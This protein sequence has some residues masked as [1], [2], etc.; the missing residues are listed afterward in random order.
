MNTL[1]RSRLAGTRGGDLG[2]WRRRDRR[3]GRAVIGDPPDPAV[4]VVGNKERAVGR[5]REPGRAERRLAGFLDRTGKTIGKD[6]KVA[7]RFAVFERLEHHV[8]ATLRQAPKFHEP[9]K[10]MKAPS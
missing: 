3:V 10:A 1:R 5:H 8:V 4:L 7:S 9:W 6:D 2:R